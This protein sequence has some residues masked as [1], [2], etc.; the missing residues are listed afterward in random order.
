[1]LALLEGSEGFIVYS[2]ASKKGLGCIQ[3]HHDRVIAFASRQLKT[4]EINYLVHNLALVAVVFVLRVWRHYLYEA[5][6]YRPQKP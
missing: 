5:Q 1:V 4:H 3:M 6:V 2:G